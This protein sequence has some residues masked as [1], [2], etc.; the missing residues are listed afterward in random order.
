[1]VP[2]VSSTSSYSRCVH[3]T[4]G[5]LLALR[6]CLSHTAG[7]EGALAPCAISPTADMNWT[8]PGASLM[9]EGKKKTTT[10]EARHLP[11]CTTIYIYLTTHGRKL[12]EQATKGSLTPTRPRDIKEELV[13]AGERW[14]KCITK[15]LQCNI[16]VGFYEQDTLT[17]A[18]AAALR[19]IASQQQK[20][21]SSASSAA[22]SFN[23]YILTTDPSLILILKRV[24]PLHG[25]VIAIKL[26]DRNVESKTL[27]VINVR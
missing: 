24:F 23:N 12:P 6:T 10:L 15:L 22:F 1:M 18:V 7:M 21:C 17:A 3:V 19:N 8:R 5:G 16:S 4:R 20:P 27:L 25:G 9:A 26:Y 14:L 13:Q 2:L 11:I